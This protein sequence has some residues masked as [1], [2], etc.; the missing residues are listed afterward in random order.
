MLAIATALAANPRLLLLDE[1]FEG[2]APYIVRRIEDIIAEI[3]D[4]QEI[5]VLLVEQNVAGAVAVA[6]HHCSRAGGGGVESVSTA[7]LRANEEVR[8]RYLG[9]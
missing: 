7:Q 5:A 6:G 9:V 4:Q 1:P 8:Q 3:N 2:L